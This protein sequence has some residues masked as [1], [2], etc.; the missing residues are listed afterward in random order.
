MEEARLLVVSSVV[1]EQSNRVYTDTEGTSKNVT[2]RMSILSGF[3][4]MM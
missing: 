3:T 4:R 1:L 2:N